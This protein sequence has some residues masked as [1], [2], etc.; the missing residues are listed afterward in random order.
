MIRAEVRV[1]DGMAVKEHKED[2]ENKT[3]V[4]KGRT[5]DRLDSRKLVPTETYDNLINR[6]LDIKPVE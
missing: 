2:E 4:V 6:L 5:K 1:G 3:L